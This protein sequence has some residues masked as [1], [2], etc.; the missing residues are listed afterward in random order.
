VSYEP[1]RII[2]A[3]RLKPRRFQSVRSMIADAQEAGVIGR[4]PALSILGGTA[5]ISALFVIA[6]IWVV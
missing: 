6:T 2:P 3:R 4:R 1:I 5:L